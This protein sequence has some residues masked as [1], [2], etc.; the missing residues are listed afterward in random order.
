MEWKWPEEAEWNGDKGEITWQNERYIL[1]LKNIVPGIKKELADVSGEVARKLVYEAAYRD[2][3]RAVNNYLSSYIASLVKKL[4]VLNEK[5]V[6]R[7]ID[8]VAQQGFGYG[9]LVKF[10]PP[11]EVIGVV[12]NSFESQYYLEN[13]IKAEKPVCDAMRGMIAGTASAILEKKTYSIETKCRALGDD[14]CEFMVTC[15]R[16]KVK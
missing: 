2:S 9:K 16:D 6:R 4:G 8:M 7:V 13:D 12:E 5:V 11:D 3:K 14:H 1:L 10:D 15:D